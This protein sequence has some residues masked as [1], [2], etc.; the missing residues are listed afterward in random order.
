M[1]KNVMHELAKEHGTP[2]MIIDHSVIRRNFTTFCK[3]IPRVH[4]YYAIKANPE[5]E[6]IKTLY[7]M[8]SGFDVASSEEFQTV[9]DNIEG[10]DQSRI[11]FMNKKVIY[12]N[13]VKRIESLELLSDTNIRMTFDNFI[14]LDKIAK[15]CNKARVVLRVDVPNEGS[16][17][18]LSTKFGADPEICL[19]LIRHAK[20][21]GLKVEG[22]SFHVGSQCKNYDN[23]IRAFEICKKLFHD[24]KD[25]GVNMNVLDI[26]GGFPVKYDGEEMTFEEFGEG[27]NDELNKYFPENGIKI[28]AEPG[29]YLVATAATSIM[30]I[31]G[32]SIRKG[33]P[34]YYVNDGCYH[35]FSGTIFDHIQYHLK[36]FKDGKLT[37]S[38]V[39]GPTCDA[40]DKISMNDPLP[41]LDL[42]DYLYAENTGA[43]TNASATNFN[44]FPPAKI[45]HLNK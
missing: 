13:P 31:H 38:A 18:E 34:F 2:L 27:L 45:L 1:E 32:K 21:L 26:G 40:L 15:F 6:I 35:T 36:A 20:K 23:Y 4:V 28:F 43:Y 16:I 41:D 33:K 42:Y 30:Q 25:L 7:N 37:E 22:L 3:T 14:E 12:A 10:E 9:Y 19:D 17:V 39:V 8:G 5:S 11:N 24:A 29:R 44:G